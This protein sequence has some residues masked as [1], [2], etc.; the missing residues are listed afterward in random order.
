MPDSV[1]A[2]FSESAGAGGCP[3]RGLLLFF[4]DY[5]FLES[6]SPHWI[7]QNSEQGCEPWTPETR[8][9][10]WLA[11]NCKSGSCRHPWEMVV[12]GA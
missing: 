10:D 5:F 2:R 12:P 7:V 8:A 1:L 11:T 6:R 4:N 3:G 9:G